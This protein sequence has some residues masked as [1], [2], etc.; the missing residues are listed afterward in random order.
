MIKYNLNLISKDHEKFKYKVNIKIPMDGFIEDVYIHIID[1]NNVYDKKLSYDHKDDKDAYFSGEISLSTKAIYKYYFSY[2]TNGEKRYLKNSYDELF[3]LSVGFEVPDWAKGKIMYHIFLDRFNKKNGCMQKLPNRDIHKSWDE[4]VVLGPNKDGIWNCD[5][6]G[7]NIEG[8]IEKLDYLKSLGVSILYISPFCKSQSN[9]RYDTGDY[10]KIDPYLGNVDNFKLLCSEAH[11][12]GMHV[13]LD[14]V[15]N[16]TGNDS[17]YF[18]EF[19]SY[20][21]VGAFQSKDSPYYKFYKKNGDNFSFWWDMKNLPVCDCNSPEWIEYITG[22]GGVI[23][24]WFELG[25]DGLRLDVADELSD[26]FIEKIREAVKRNKSDGFIL[27]EV[28][29]NPMRM[30]RVYLS[31]GKGMDSVMNYLLVDALIRYYKFSDVSK[32]KNVLDEIMREYP[33]DTIFS[34]MNFTSTHDISRAIE[35]FACNFFNPNNEWVWDVDNSNH[36]FLRNHKLT[37]EE[38]IKG[39]EAYKSYLFALTFLPGNLSIFYGDE[40]GLEGL[41]NLLNR[42]PYPWGKED[43]SLIDYF[44]FLGKIRGENSFLEN[45]SFHVKDLNP[46]Y[47]MFERMRDD[48]SCLVVVSR[49]DNGRIYVPPE[50]D[51]PSKV[52]TL[53]NSSHNGLSP[54]GAVALIK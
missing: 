42:R 50:Y 6:F 52:Y 47:F 26:Y 28:W 37:R 8:I 13:I 5:F 32:L 51:S 14:A 36:D 10:L 35:I 39:L 29:K 21:N 2:N 4:D 41:G 30:N 16:H 19:G 46:N 44:R 43:I 27:G 33:D 54:Y 23:D 38:Y 45:A 48:N 49:N 9:H 12:R 18:N 17:K 15:F 3:K 31:S 40:A 1:G 24:R 22:E 25:I 7:G 53:G 11:K 20:D 34:L